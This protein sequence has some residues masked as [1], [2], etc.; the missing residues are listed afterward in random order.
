MRASGRS[1]SK[2]RP[3]TLIMQMRGGETAALI[4]LLEAAFT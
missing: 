3:Y 1:L 2:P 4:D